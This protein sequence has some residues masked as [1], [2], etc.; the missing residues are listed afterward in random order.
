MDANCNVKLTLKSGQEI[1]EGCRLSTSRKKLL[2]NCGTHMC[3]SFIEVIRVS[4]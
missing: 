3:S 4:S 1:K 2:C